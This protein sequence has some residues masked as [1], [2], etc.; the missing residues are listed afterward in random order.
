MKGVKGF[1]A[2][3]PMVVTIRGGPMGTF[4]Q[5]FSAHRSSIVFCE[6]FWW[7]VKIVFQS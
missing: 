2:A 6:L 4:S 7:A 1:D 3:E 5:R